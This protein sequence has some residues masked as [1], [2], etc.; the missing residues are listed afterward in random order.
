MKTLKSYCVQEINVDEM[1]ET[2]GGWVCAFIV[3]AIIGGIIYDVAKAGYIAAAEGYLNA[4]MNGTYD[5][6]PSPS[7]RH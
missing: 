3:G 7:F 1:K 4:S 6:M 2:D 5:G